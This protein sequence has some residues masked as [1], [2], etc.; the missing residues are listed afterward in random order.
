MLSADRKPPAAS[1]QPT[2]VMQPD[3]TE[4]ISGFTTLASVPSTAL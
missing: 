3:P 4:Q 1:T 2:S